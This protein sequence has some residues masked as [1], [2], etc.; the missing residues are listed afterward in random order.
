[1]P[2]P[3]R[4]GIAGCGDIARTVHLP[5]WSTLSHVEV[6]AL[7]DHDAGN[8][9]AAAA[10]AKQVR[11]FAHWQEMVADP[12]IDVVVICLPS[13][14][15]AS[16]AIATLEAGKHL[17]LEKPL[18]TQLSDARR[19]ID[20]ARSA[21]KSVA[22]VGFNL[23]WHP[24]YQQVRAAMDAGRYGTT[25]AVRTLFSTRRGTRPAWATGPGGGGAFQELLA[26]D[27]DLVRFLLRQPVKS[28]VASVRTVESD[29]DTVALQ[30]TM[31]DDTPVQML[32]SLS[33]VETARLELLG[34][35]AGV[36]VS[37][38]DALTPR[39]LRTR[40]RGL[41][42]M[43]VDGA[44]QLTGVDYLWAKMRAPAH[45][46]SFRP[47][48]EA[49]VQRVRAGQP[50]D[51]GDLENAFHCLAVLDAAQCSVRQARAV[52]PETISP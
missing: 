41:R 27:V 35:A 37:R 2:Q 51:P 49:F 20:A 8:L 28:V 11:R 44:T 22:T 42:G 31:A 6:R 14:L 24:M 16:A 25:V 32:A 17:Y 7:A 38:Y 13:P 48:F 39:T 45:E 30:L 4:L 18:A 9:A 21:R 10:Q 3:L 12:E 34:S 36:E 1:M 50:G 23:R 15:H 5:L 46:P 26:H 19:V 29:E 52:T 40:A 43:L 47:M 33:S